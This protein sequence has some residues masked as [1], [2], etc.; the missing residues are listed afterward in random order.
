M[1]QIG[2]MKLAV[3]SLLAS[4][5]AAGCSAGSGGA[6]TDGGATPAIEP[7]PLRDGGTA[8]A[9]EG[10]TTTGDAAT[11]QPVPLTPHYDI[12]IDGKAAPVTQLFLNGAT[13]S[14][15][16]ATSHHVSV[17]G[18]F[19][20]SAIPYASNQDANM[21]LELTHDLPKG[22]FTC[23]QI[24]LTIYYSLPGGSTESRPVHPGGSCAVTITEPAAGLWT[25]G[26]VSGVATSYD[27]S[28]PV[29]FTLSWAEKTVE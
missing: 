17:Q 23:D 8:P 22:T 4:F 12:T 25:A 9:G 13:D 3:A 1:C 5:L 14:T 21:W 11:S 28:R 2:L 29:P 20:S 27:G 24:D 16:T 18:L 15:K 19:A 7:D 6:F 10:G 26:T